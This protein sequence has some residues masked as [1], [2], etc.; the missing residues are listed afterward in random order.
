MIKFSASVLILA[1]SVPFYL[2]WAKRQTDRQI[3]KMQK[4][5]FNSPGTEAPVPPGVV[6]GG[7]GVLISHFMVAR[8]LLKLRLWQGILSLLL[9]GAAGVATF[10]AQRKG[11]GR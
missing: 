11:A 6:L 8:Q 5:V 7:I 4:A 3:D 10:F 9:G 2:M 1:V